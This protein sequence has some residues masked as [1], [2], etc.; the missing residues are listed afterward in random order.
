MAEE[1]ILWFLSDPLIGTAIILVIGIVLGSFYS[2]VRD[3]FKQMEPLYLFFTKDRRFHWRFGRMPD[4][5]YLWKKDTKTGDNIETKVT[6]THY[7]SALGRPVHII[8]EEEPENID[9]FKENEETK[10]SKDLNQLVLG[11]IAYGQNMESLLSSQP[12]QMN[13]LYI[14]LILTCAISAVLSGIL[15]S[16]QFGLLDF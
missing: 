10:S 12:V 3:F 5:K 1:D 16:K 8:A 11:G 6:K 13:N 9:L 15:V 7:V 2:K 14:I 4:D